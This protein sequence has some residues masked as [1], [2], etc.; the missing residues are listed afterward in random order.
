MNGKLWIAIGGVIALLGCSKESAPE[1]KRSSGKI[2]VVATTTMVSD[3]VRQVGGDKVE[4]QGLMGPGVDPHLYKALASDITKLQGADVIF[5]SGLVL[6][7]KMQDVFAKMART[8]K[9]VYPVTEAIPQDRLLEPPEFAG[10]YD[11]H[12]WFEVPLW[13]KCVD[14]VVHGLSDFAPQHK[15]YFE[16]QGKATQ[17]KMQALHQWAVKRASELAMEKRI[18]ITSHDAFNYFGRA[19][20]FRVVGLQGISTVEEA[21]MA[22]MVKMVEFIKKNNVKAIFVETS[23]PQQAI[24]RISQDAG[25]GIGGELFSDAMGTPGK[26]E[27][28]YDL[29]SYEGMIKHNLNSIVDALK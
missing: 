8:K 11:P 1:A 7:G 29:G 18:L 9:H 5:Y 15:D 26:I 4:V 24:R 12:V 14:V 6:E 28:D 21:N 16:K 13:T 20:G 10:H 3:L 27:R 2:Q 19:Y 22:S 25:V 17:A 23:V